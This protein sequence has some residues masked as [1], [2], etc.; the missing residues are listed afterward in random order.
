MDKQIA[1]DILKAAHD[2]NLFYSIT[3]RL[4]FYTEDISEEVDDMRWLDTQAAQSLIDDGY[5]IVD[6]EYIPSFVDVDREVFLTDS[7][8]QFLEKLE[9]ELAE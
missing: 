1:F 8:Y 5:L 4:G 3:Y 7:G 6:D 9:R 2:K